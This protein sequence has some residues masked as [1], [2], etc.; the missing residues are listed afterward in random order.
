VT[1]VAVAALALATAHASG[2]VLAPERAPLLPEF[3]QRSAAG[4]LNSPPLGVADL[5]GK[6]VLLDFWTFDC[7]NCYRSIPWLQD[8]ERRYG[9]R[10][11]R[12][13]GIHS[14]EFAHE[15]VPANVAAKVAEFKVAH[16]VMLDADH[17]YWRALGNQYWPAF[18]LVDRRGRI[19]GTAIGETHSG[20]AQA[21]AVESAIELL[22]A[23]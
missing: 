1:R 4:W 16:P 13:I 21:R 23:E 9:A 10:G 20:D 11:L 8:L 12:V 5:R 6:V 15:R 18:Y 3:T 22:L 17:A 19:R 14:P 7:F 2:G